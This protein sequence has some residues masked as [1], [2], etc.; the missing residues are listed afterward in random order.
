MIFSNIERFQCGGNPHKGAKRDGV[1]CANK[2][3]K[4][5]RGCDSRQ[6]YEIV[7]G[8]ETWVKF[9]EPQRKQQSKCWLPTGSYPPEKARP[10]FRYDKVTAYSSMHM[11]QL[12]KYLYLKDH[13]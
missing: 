6:L 10:D 12:P 7:T 11:G 2:L 8:N 3:L 13:D 1:S 4:E 9:S 5:Y